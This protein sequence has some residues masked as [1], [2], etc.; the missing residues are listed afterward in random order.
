MM[1]APLHPRE[2]TV[3]RQA[4]MLSSQGQRLIRSTIQPAILLIRTERSSIN[5]RSSGCA[6][7]QARGFSPTPGESFA[8]GFDEGRERICCVEDNVGLL[9]L[10]ED[11]IAEPDE[12]PAESARVPDAV[13]AYLF[14]LCAKRGPTQFR[15]QKVDTR[16]W[17]VEAFR[18]FSGQYSSVRSAWSWSGLTSWY[19][20]PWRR[21]SQRYSSPQAAKR[22]SW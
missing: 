16:A 7:S 15:W 12:L 5:P 21:C 17:L 19:I 6:R 20:F 13:K 18:P 11:D 22:R 2:A 4:A 3:I 10:V 1:L 9:L 14:D 8:D